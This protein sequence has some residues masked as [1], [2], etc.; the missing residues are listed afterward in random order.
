MLTKA[1][2]Q[3]AIQD[4]IGNY[5]AIAALAQAG[6]PRVLQHMDAMAA[7]LAMLSAQIEAAQAEPFEKVRDATVLSDAAMRG[8]VRKGSPARVRLRA[9]N[10][11]AAPYSLASGRTL[12]D[13]T[14][15]AYRVE[16]AVNVPSGGAATFEATQV[17]FATVRH[18]VEGSQPF[19]AIEVPA[20]ED[21]SFL[22]SI[23]VSDA[24]GEF[25]YRDR[26]VNTAAGER[27]F[28]VEADD[29]Q[30]IYARFGY[31]DVVGVQPRD[32]AALTLTVGYT[33]GDIQ[34]AGGTPFSFEYLSSP[35][36]SSVELKMDAM[37][38]PGQ[39]PIPMSVLRDLARYPSVYASN[40]VF[41]GEFDFLVRRSFPSLRFLSVWNEAAEEV[42]RG[43]SVDS[44]NALFI[45]CLAQDARE[46]VL[47]ADGAGEIPEPALIPKAEWTETQHAIREAI[48]AADDSY[49]VYFV[50]P[51]RVPI[52]IT[53]TAKVPTSY[54][55]TDVRQKIV[56]AILS[57]YGEQATA[58]R[59]GRN[60]PLYQNVYALLRRRVDALSVGASDLQVSIAAPQEA[61]ARPELWRYVSPDSLTVTVEAAN[62]VAPAWGG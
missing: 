36:E 30:R 57:E 46:T 24:A 29:R 18:V 41:L 14:G 54:I 11:G 22:C 19:Y 31:A 5:P 2:F 20:A 61:A 7:M 4:S 52:A 39:N 60:Q 17:R 53:I 35:M 27:V 55:T 28:H 33:D 56:E 62:I 25:A 26:Y 45:A 44:I 10:K 48:R 37:L 8:I 59:R 12:L 43:P 9:E 6:D 58:S 49:R 50:S 1:D 34:L 47:T 51:V 15:R 38:A 3:R 42:A 23:A 32:G 21:D 40:A 16:T 13:S